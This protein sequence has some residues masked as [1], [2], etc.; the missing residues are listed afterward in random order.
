MSVKPIIKV[1]VY[2]AVT[3]IVLAV[4]L[5]CAA[6]QANGPPAAWNGLNGGMTRQEITAL[7]GPPEPASIPGSDLWRSHGWELQI[8]YEQNGRA[9]NIVRHPVGK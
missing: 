9:R 7:I 6:P 8:D 2:R 4:L 3:A 1:Q 5:G